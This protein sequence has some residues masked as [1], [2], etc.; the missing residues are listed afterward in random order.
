MELTGSFAPVRAT[1]QMALLTDRPRTASAAAAGD[2]R[3]LALNR[4]TLRRIL[5]PFS[6]ILKRDKGLY[7]AFMA[8]K[9]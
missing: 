6:D 9:L 8:Q 3:L 2:A 5:G 7:N 4:T 1:V